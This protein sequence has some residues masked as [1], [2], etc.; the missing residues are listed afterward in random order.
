MGVYERRKIGCTSVKHAIR[1]SSQASYILLMD[2]RLNSGRPGRNVSIFDD[3][4]G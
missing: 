4:M 1:S 2:R 3:G